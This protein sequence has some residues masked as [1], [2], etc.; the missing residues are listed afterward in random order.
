MLQLLSKE[1]LGHVL[2]FLHGLRPSRGDYEEEWWLLDWK[3]K[4]KSK[5]FWAAHH[6]CE[7]LKKRVA[8]R[9]ISYPCCD[10]VFFRNTETLLLAQNTCREWYIV[11]QSYK[12]QV[13][14]VNDSIHQEF[15]FRCRSEAA[16]S[17]RYNELMFAHLEHCLASGSRRESRLF[18]LKFAKF[19]SFVYNNDGYIDY[20]TVESCTDMEECEHVLESTCEEM[21]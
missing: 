15:I 5:K 4:R 20:E 13:Q 12:I 9:M 14:H 16:Q 19:A 18:W 1:L 8:E 21:S 3:E 11:L 6:K 2:I 7:E 10:H 17:L